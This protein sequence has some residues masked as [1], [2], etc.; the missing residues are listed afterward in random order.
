[1]IRTPAAR[2]AAFRTGPLSLA[3]SAAALVLAACA[4]DDAPPTFAI[5]TVAGVPRVRNTGPAETVDTVPLATIGSV[6]FE[7]AGTPDEFGSVASVVADAAGNI[8]VADGRSREVRVFDESGTH[9]RT[10]GRGGGGPGEFGN[11]Y[12]LA[13]MGDTLLA[14]DPGNARVSLLSTSGEE[15]G[16][17]RW[18]PLTGSGSLVRFYPTGPREAYVLFVKQDSLRPAAQHFVRLLPSGPADTVALD[19]PSDLT[20]Y[21]VVCRAEGYI[22]YFSVPF[23]PGFFGT[24]A[25][26]VQVAQVRTE[27]YR[28][29]LA[30][31]RGDTVRVVEGGEPPLPVREEAW[32]SLMGEFRT[33]REG[34]AGGPTCN[35]REPV[36]PPSQPVLRGIFFAHDGMLV[37]EVLTPAGF[38]YDFFD[39]DGVLRRRAPAPARDPEVPPFFRNGIVY[40]AVRDSLDVPAVRSFRLSPTPTFRDP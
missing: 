12:S 19:R 32:D 36:R 27:A 20:P 21:G 15:Y 11:L 5:D 40:V 1:M 30:D 35:Q 17:W 3:L 39:A 4:G 14:L 10:F 33:W 16:T 7:T 13:W 22:S 18:M 38:V 2:A 8:Y 31:A 6:G 28:Y 23:A 37:A 34:L 24:P 29:A 26:G 25:A 9:L